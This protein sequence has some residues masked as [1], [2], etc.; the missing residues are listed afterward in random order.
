MKGRGVEKPLQPD[1]QMTGARA[2][3]PARDVITDQRRAGLYLV[4]S[5]NGKK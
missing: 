5:V 1:D 4:V 3:A 2:Q